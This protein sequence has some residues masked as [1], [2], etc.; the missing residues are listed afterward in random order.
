MKTPA[1]LLPDLETLTTGLMAVLLTEPAEGPPLTILERRV[2]QMMSTFPNEDVTCVLPDGRQQ[3]VFIKY[4]AGRDHSAYGHRGGIAY[5]AE[6]YRRVLCH[7]PKSTP[8]FLGAQTN[9]VTGETWLFLEHLDRSARVSDLIEHQH[10]ATLEVAQWIGEFH[11]LH[12]PLSESP[13]LSFLRR[14]DEAYYRGWVHRMYDFT[15]PM[16]EQ[17][18]WVAE[19]CLRCEE[20]IALL[21]AAPVTVIHGEFYTKNVLQHNQQVYPVDW[22]SAAVAPGEIDLAALTEGTGWPQNVVR[23]FE[24]AYRRARWPEGAPDHFPHT[25]D[26]ARMYLHCRWLGESF[27]RAASEKSRWRYKQLHATAKA[28]G[29]I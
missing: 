24:R 23:Q 4:E 14:Y 6:V 27:Q 2:P 1:A 8:T 3:R 7:C 9:C 28:L 13:D 19:L 20:W 29:L 17:F 15:A 16:R 5:E 18:P 10:L 21:Q 25:L 11:A 26:A 12:Q 22:E